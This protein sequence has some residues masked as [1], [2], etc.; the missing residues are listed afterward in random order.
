MKTRVRYTIVVEVEGEMDEDFDVEIV[1]ETV[2][3]NGAEGIDTGKKTA[4]V[5]SI[6]ADVHYTKTIKKE[7]P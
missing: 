3:R 7:Q 5:K 2:A 6:K 1:G 4:V